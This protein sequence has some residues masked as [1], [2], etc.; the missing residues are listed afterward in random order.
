[1]RSSEQ[2]GVIQKIKTEMEVL[3]YKPGLIMKLFRLLEQGGSLQI[4][5]FNLIVRFE[6]LKM[7]QSP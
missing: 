7:H 2:F 4:L 3:K 6:W 5:T 1:M